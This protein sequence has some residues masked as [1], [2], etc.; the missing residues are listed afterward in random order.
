MYQIHPV[1][2]GAPGFRQLAIKSSIRFPINH[3]AHAVVLMMLPL[4][5]VA[6][7]LVVMLCRKL[8]NEVPPASPSA[9][10]RLAKLLSRSVFVDDEL[11]EVLESLAEAV[12]VEEVLDSD[13]DND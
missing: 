10:S 7:N 6:C 3:P 12:S 11:P 9:L 5:G 2:A 1:H 13:A 8:L 4:D